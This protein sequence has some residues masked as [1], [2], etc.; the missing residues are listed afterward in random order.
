MSRDEVIA[1]LQAHKDEL[2][3]TRVV[4][5]SPLGST[6]RDE[7]TAQDIDVTVR[8]AREFSRPE[9]DYFGRLEALEEQLTRTLGLRSG[10]G[11]GISS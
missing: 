6:P 8:L 9:F 11:R 7:K 10:S 3:S 1:L 2:R 4:G 5:V